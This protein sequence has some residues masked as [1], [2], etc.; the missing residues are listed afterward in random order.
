MIR[1]KCVRPCRRALVRQKQ[2][3]LEKLESREVPSGAQ[4]DHI[5]LLAGGGASPFGSPGPTGYTPAQ[6]R[7][8]Y[9]F[10]QIKF[11]GGTVIFGGAWTPNP[12]VGTLGHPP[13][14]HDFP[15]FFP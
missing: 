7:H 2:L 3:S 8:A 11:N 13:V 1:S 12:I 15:A 10:D 4:P 9:G 14:P 5:Q 6:I